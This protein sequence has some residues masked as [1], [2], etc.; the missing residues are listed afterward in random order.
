MYAKLC[1]EAVV[2][3]AIDILKK[4]ILLDAVNL[5]VTHLG[6][7]DASFVSSALLIQIHCT[8]TSCLTD[9]IQLDLEYLRAHLWDIR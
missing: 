3:R 6:E 4:E 1:G 9:L 2:E 5:G 8:K 7:L